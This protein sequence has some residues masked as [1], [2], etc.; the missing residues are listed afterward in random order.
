MTALNGVCRAVRTN[1]GRFLIR[2]M[3]GEHRPAAHVIANFIR[4]EIAPRHRSARSR[5]MTSRPACASGSTAT[6]PPA[7][8]PMT[9]TSGALSL[10][11][12]FHVSG[13]LFEKR[14]RLVEAFEVVGR[15]VIRLELA[16]FERF[17]I[18][19]RHHRPHARVAEQIP[20]DE[21]RVTTVVR[22]AEGALPRVA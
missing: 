21:I 20:S 13:M 2:L 11:A 12:M 16:G 1:G 3:A 8:S 15:L 9:T 5:P 10:V 18:G 6:P 14:C 22:V 17:L 7:P 19:R 4:R